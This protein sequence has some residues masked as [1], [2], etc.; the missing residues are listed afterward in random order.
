MCLN[1]EKYVQELK[2]RNA[3]D[4]GLVAKLKRDGW[5]EPAADEILASSPLEDDKRF[6]TV[7]AKTFL[8]P[9]R[10]TLPKTDGPAVMGL[11]VN[12]KLD[13]LTVHLDAMGRFVIPDGIGR[14]VP[15]SL[16]SVP[17]PLPDNGEGIGNDDEE[18]ETAEEGEDVVELESGSSDVEG[19]S[20]THVVLLV[21]ALRTGELHQ[22]LLAIGLMET[23]AESTVARRQKLAAAAAA[24]IKSALIRRPIKFLPTTAVLTP[25]GHT[26]VYNVATALMGCEKMRVHIHVHTGCVCKGSQSCTNLQLATDRCVAISGLLKKHLGTQEGAHD[27]VIQ[28]HGCKHAEIGSKR[29]VRIVTQPLVA[30]SRPAGVRDKTSVRMDQLRKQGLQLLR[31][32]R[33]TV[34]AASDYCLHD[35]E[36]SQDALLRLPLKNISMVNIGPLSLKEARQ[37]ARACAV[38]GKSAEGGETMKHS[39]QCALKSLEIDLLAKHEGILRK[40]SGGRGS[41][42][43]LSPFYLS[44]A[45]ATL[46]ASSN[47]PLA[48]NS[49]AD[50]PTSTATLTDFVVDRLEK[51]FGERVVGEVIQD[52]LDHPTG[53][54]CDRIP[55]G[56]TKA[57]PTS[58]TS[59]AASARSVGSF[60]V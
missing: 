5:E 13:P 11:A 19:Q 4:G 32:S 53:L 3:S 7:L 9:I 48:I 42:G 33:V 36:S 41:H 58:S 46:F 40:D 54:R 25:A 43:P 45:V 14:N 23:P 56:K 44:A 2:A 52:I 20:R 27:L 8:N 34:I 31:G 21:D 51:L 17:D 28:A 49:S 1:K 26:A 16:V 10:Y 12:L 55:R 30:N 39:L 18:H 35:D 47:A 57:P 60:S 15:I 50:F 24:I 59:G 37:V 29:C 6:S 22:L 38:G